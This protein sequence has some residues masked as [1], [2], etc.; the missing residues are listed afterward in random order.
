MWVRCSTEELLPAIYR[1][2][3]KRP[4]CRGPDAF[5]L[6]GLLPE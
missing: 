3:F 2:E 5:A 1:R 4:K 6:C